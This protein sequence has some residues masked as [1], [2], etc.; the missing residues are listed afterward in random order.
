[1]RCRIT[2]IRRAN[3]TMALFRPRRF[4]TWAPQVLSQVARPRFIMTVAAWHNAR[5]RFTS[6]ALVMLPKTSR[7]P[8]WL[9][10]GVSPTQG[11]TFL[12][13][14]AYS[15]TEKRSRGPQIEARNRLKFGHFLSPFRSKKTAG[16]RHI[17]RQSNP[18][19]SSTQGTSKSISDAILSSS[20]FQNLAPRSG[21]LKTI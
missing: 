15:A 18:F 17:K 8:D 2:E 3:A 13:G 12:E 10:D 7:S 4:A 16:F 11:P 20:K 6:P 21:R 19:K 9:R 14:E 1:M 5:L